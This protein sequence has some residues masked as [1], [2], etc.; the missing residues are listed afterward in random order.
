M[1]LVCA[2]DKRQQLTGKQH[3]A[4]AKAET[5]P[6]ALSEREDARPFE[7]RSAWITPHVYSTPRY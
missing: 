2:L 5:A 7:R 6:M 4:S 3:M 1:A